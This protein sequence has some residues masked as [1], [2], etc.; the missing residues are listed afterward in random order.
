MHCFVLM[1]RQSLMKTSSAVWK[2]RAAECPLNSKFQSSYFYK[3]S[4]F[5]VYNTP[6]ERY[7]S[8]FSNSS[9]CIPIEWWKY[10]LLL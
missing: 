1:T 7:R 6:L 3:I 4:I 2:D 9:C 5:V 10:E 8:L